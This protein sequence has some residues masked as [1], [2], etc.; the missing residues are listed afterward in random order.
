MRK[1]DEVVVLPSGKSSRVKSI[2][3]STASWRRRLRRM[4]V[5]LTLEDEI[6]VSRGDLLV[7]RQPAA[8]SGSS[9]PWWSGW[10]KFRRAR[11]HVLYQA[12]HAA[13]PGA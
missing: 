7:R 11:P 6:D 9:T 1:G 5:T 10:P 3:T 12:R 13:V 2:V 8:V 4:A